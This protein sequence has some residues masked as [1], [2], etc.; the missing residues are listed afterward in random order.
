MTIQTAIVM[1][2][3]PVCRNG[4]QFSVE[5]WVSTKGATQNIL[6]SEYIKGIITIA[7]NNDTTRYFLKSFSPTF[8][9]FHLVLT[10]GRSQSMLRVMPPIIGRDVLYHVSSQVYGSAHFLTSSGVPANAGSRQK[11][12]QAHCV[13]GVIAKM[14]ATD[15]MI[16]RN[17][18]LFNYPHPPH[19]MGVYFCYIS[20]MSDHSFQR[21]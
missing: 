8:L 14:M 7:I 6:Q 16:S 12:L 1:R 10:R 3:Y 19:M 21:W 9:D 11:V 13:T 20:V 4:S 18:R 5:K 2:P 15:T 17:Q